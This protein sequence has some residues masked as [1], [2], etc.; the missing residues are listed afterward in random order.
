L[1]RRQNAPE[2]HRGGKHC[3]FNEGDV[4]R[5]P[6]SPKMRKMTPVKMCRPHSGRASSMRM[7]NEHFSLPK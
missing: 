4:R 1:V 2:K 5:K 3:D 7:K 6:K